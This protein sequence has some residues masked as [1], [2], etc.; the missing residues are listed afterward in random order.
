[1]LKEVF[2]AEA[3]ANVRV[4]V[5]TEIRE[6]TNEFSGRVFGGRSWK[7]RQGCFGSRESVCDGL[8]DVGKPARRET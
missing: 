8:T 2:V 6:E 3:A 1:L 4:E 5:V 7:I